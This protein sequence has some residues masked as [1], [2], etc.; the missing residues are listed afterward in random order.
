M[1]PRPDRQRLDLGPLHAA[2]DQRLARWQDERFGA[3]LWDRDHR[4]W[5]RQLVPEIVDRLGWLTLPETMAGELAAIEEFAAGVQGDGYRHVVL[6]G[7]G[8]S[9]LAP[10]VFSR[11]F[12]AA[13][14][15]PELLVLDSTHPDSVLAVSELLDPASTMFLVSSKSGTTVEPLSMFRFFWEWVATATAVPGRHFAAVTDPGTPLADLG[16]E[17]A[18]RAVFTA[19]PDVGGRYSALSHFG[20]V[21]AA[22]IGVDAGALLASA[23]AMAA[24]CG[25]A[26]ADIHNPA[27]QLGAALGEAALAGRD[28]ATLLTSPA[29]AAFPEWAEQLIAESTGKEGTGVVPVA[30]EPVAPPTAYGS[31]RFFVYLAVEGDEDAPQAAAV[32]ALA[33]AGHPVA[34]ITLPGRIDVAAEMFRAELATAAAGAVL[35]IHPFNQP[36]VQRA[37]ELAHQ[38]LSGDLDASIGGVDATQ[39][40][41]LG[42]AVDS[43]LASARPGDYV[44]LHAYLAP[45][46]EVDRALAR[47]RLALRDRLQAATT[48]GYGPRFLHS[49][50]QLHKGGPDSG[51]FLQIVDEPSQPAL[52]PGTGYSF[53]QLIAG[54]ADGDYQALRDAG[55]RVL[56]VHVGTAAQGLPALEAAVA[57]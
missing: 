36:D 49:T 2:V 25:P 7:M 35:G 12:G 9:S 6:L 53:A 15:R 43:W 27:L 33:A 3:R 29:L 8:G 40:G 4:L 24:A 57:R 19:T 39:P 54:Q 10:D 14:G 42:D 20:L 45:T 17:H 52:V 21:P 28:K 26:V 1:E 18:F 11:T 30:G 31:D 56:R 16:A 51:L 13:P 38:A 55:R 23:R 37:K 50:G 47:M 32:A 22:L 41:P 44:A 46:P 5:S 48:V 34:S